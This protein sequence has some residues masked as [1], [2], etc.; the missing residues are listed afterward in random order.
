ML[1]AFYMHFTSTLRAFYME[2]LNGKDHKQNY[3]LKFFLHYLQ[4]DVNI[5]LISYYW[6]LFK[7]SLVVKHSYFFLYF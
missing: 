1:H 5:F 4:Y 7:I 6:R 3:Q 2:N